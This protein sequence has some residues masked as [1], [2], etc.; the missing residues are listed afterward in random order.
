M[1]VFVSP[2][3]IDSTVNFSSILSI[4]VNSERSN[5]HQQI[6]DERPLQR[7][8]RCTGVDFVL[9]FKCFY[10]VNIAF[11]FLYLMNL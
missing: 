5:F 8:L 11:Y 2:L 7:Y 1:F 9:N 4:Q 6:F 3:R 10:L